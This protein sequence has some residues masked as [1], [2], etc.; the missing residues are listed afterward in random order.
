MP[1]SV[2]HCSRSGFNALL[3]VSLLLATIVIIYTINLRSIATRNRT[4]LLISSILCIFVSV[5]LLVLKENYLNQVALLQGMPATSRVAA[6]YHSYLGNT[7]VINHINEKNGEILYKTLI[8][9][10]H[11]L[12]NTLPDGTSLDS[13]TYVLEALALKF[14]PENDHVLILGLG[15]GIMPMQM[16]RRGSDVTV[17]ELDAGI[18]QS[19]IEH[20][21]FNS[22]NINLIQEDARTFVRHCPRSYDTIVVDLFQGDGVPDY[23][24]TVEFFSDIKTCMTINSTLVMNTFY[25][26]DDEINLHI[27]ATLA[28]TFP[29]LYEAVWSNDVHA[30]S[31]DK[32]INRYLVGRLKE[33]EINETPVIENMPVLLRKYFDGPISKLKKIP[34]ESLAD[35]AVITDE[36][37][38]YNLVYAKMQMAYR[39]QILKILPA[40]FLT[41]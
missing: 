18:M 8:Q 4:R 25:N 12:N 3:G 24:M 38:F 20:F 5:S 27:S 1:I 19:S 39:N 21:N 29:V 16:Y 40:N 2:I 7:K 28:R 15:A 17:V 30:T 31:E 22:A 14:S 9:D 34:V 23:M 13:Y 26:N 6:E 11:I 33:A 36:K 35:I 41:N 10:G 32:I 37:N